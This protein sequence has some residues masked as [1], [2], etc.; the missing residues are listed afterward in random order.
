[1]DDE[2][3]LR[4]VKAGEPNSR[5]HKRQPSRAEKEMAARGEKPYKTNLRELC[6]IAARKAES[7]YEFRDMLDGWDVDTSFRNGKLYVTDRDNDR[8]TFSVARLD[9]GLDM[10]GLDR[11]FRGNIVREIQRK[12]REAVEAMEAE[13]RESE[14]VRKMV[15]SYVADARERF[16][17]YRQK[18]KAMAGKPYAELP[19]FGL[20][21]PPKEIERDPEVRR[22]I[23]AYWR[24][25]DELRH[26]LACDVPRGRPARAQSVRQPEPQPRRVEQARPQPQRGQER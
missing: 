7:I 22:T 13:R 23:L 18:V 12:G 1:M 20:A 16:V 3:G 10:D 8:L 14:R 24:G 6:R 2:W 21:R 9:S 19:R 5:I 11:A 4:Q 15:E 17:A 26:K 25:G